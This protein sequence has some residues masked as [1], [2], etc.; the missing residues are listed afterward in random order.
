M[1]G[2]VDPTV[3]AGGKCFPCRESKPDSAA[4]A[5]PL[6]RRHSGWKCAKC[7]FLYHTT[8]QDQAV[9][10]LCLMSTWRGKSVSL[11]IQKLCTDS[12]S[13][14][15]AVICEKDKRKPA[16]HCSCVR[17]RTGKWSEM[18]LTT[19]SM[20]CVCVCVCVCVWKRERERADMC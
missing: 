10:V 2:L 20:Y 15:Y 13:A 12:T 19:H 7:Q 3:R 17:A 1:R 4:A 18:K 16:Q 11:N 14:M 9:F 6:T 5:T 8:C